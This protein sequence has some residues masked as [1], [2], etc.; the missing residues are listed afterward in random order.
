VIAETRSLFRIGTVCDV[1]ELTSAYVVSCVSG[2]Q[3]VVVVSDGQGTCVRSA[4]SAI[5]MPSGD[6]VCPH[7][8]SPRRRHDL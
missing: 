3:P 8:G 6:T 5:E 4:G 1:T 7:S 2:D